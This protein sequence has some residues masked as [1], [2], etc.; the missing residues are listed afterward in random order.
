LDFPPGHCIFILGIFT[1]DLLIRLSYFLMS[2]TLNAG[3]SRASRGALPAA[4]PVE[5]RGIP[6]SGNSGFEF[7]PVTIGNVRFR[8][9][10]YISSGPTTRNIRQLMKAEECGWAGASI[11]LVIDPAPYINR[12]PRYG[13][14]AQQGIF[15][16]TAEKRLT[17]DQGLRLVE[18]GRKKTSEL[19]ILA[20]ITYAGDKGVEEGWGALAKRFEDAGAHVIELNMCCPNM[21]FNVE[22]SGRPH[23]GGPKTGASLG[24]D[25]E[26]VG[27]ITRVVREMVDIPVFVKLTPEGGKIAQVAYTIE[28]EGCEDLGVS[29]RE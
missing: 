17:P 28:P 25:A 27:H 26:A 13:W 8:N 5:R 9:P 2:G 21:S 24:Q 6:M 11:K 15:S 20:N 22:V 3:T 12:E 7:Q 4:E 14:F 29:P 19:V 1:L 10:F 16:F 18:E 23:E